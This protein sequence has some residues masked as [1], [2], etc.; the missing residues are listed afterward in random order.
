M[1][2]TDLSVIS[3]VIAEAKKCYQ[4]SGLDQA[5]LLKLERLWKKKLLLL[6]EEDEEEEQ[7]DVGASE[8][9]PGSSG[10][11]EIPLSS[12]EIEVVRVV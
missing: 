12:V 2:E 8:E 4:D 3:T 5:S 1:S 6:T 11:E 10:E 7:E 9:E